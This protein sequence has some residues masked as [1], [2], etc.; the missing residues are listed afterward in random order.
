MPTPTVHQEG[1]DSA[2]SEGASLSERIRKQV[3][4]SLGRPPD[5]LSVQVRPVGG[6]NYRINV[7]VGRAADSPRI[8]NSYFLT[9]DAEGRIIA[10]SPKILKQYH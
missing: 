6:E 2:P 7:V 9:T 1:Q 4:R 5:L 8:A 3:V 10:S